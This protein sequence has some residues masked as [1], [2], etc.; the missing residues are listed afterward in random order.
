MTDMKINT[1]SK[2]SLSVALL[3]LN[4]SSVADTA[5]DS[6]N[7]QALAVLLSD[8][9]QT[10]RSLT[11]VPSNLKPSQEHIITS[12]DTLEKLA[13]SSYGNTPLNQE[14]VQKIILLKN[15]NAFFRGNGD[16]PL[17]GEK[18]IIPSLDDIRS[19]V[20]SYKS[21]KKFPHTPQEQWIRYP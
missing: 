9:A 10:Q 1:L 14:I 20:F 2:T 16:F 7:E 13:M 8:F 6:A 3:L 18:I 5:Q 15:P 12:E 21:G 11:Q 17:V 4:L 19:Y